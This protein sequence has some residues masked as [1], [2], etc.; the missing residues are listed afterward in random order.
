MTASATV[1]VPEALERE[2]NE[3]HR[4]VRAALMD[5][6][7]AFTASAPL[8]DYVG[9]LRLYLRAAYLLTMWLPE[10]EL[11]RRVAGD[12][13]A[14]IVAMKLFDDLLDG[15]SGFDR[16]EL[17]LCLLLEQR[18][19]SRLA[20]RAPDPQLV[21]DTLE[22]NFVTVGIGQ[23]RTKREPAEDVATWRA[24]AE[25]YGACFLG[26]YGT[27]A[28]LSGGVPEALPAATNFG[29]GFGMIV[30]VADDMRDYERHGE[31]AGNLGHLLLT[32]RAAE[33]EI[34]DLIEQARRLATPPAGLWAAHDVTP[35]VNLYADDV[36]HRVLPA[37]ATL[38]NGIG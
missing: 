32:G 14:H 17:G 12:L 30:T 1:R 5:T 3:G 27:L 20:R 33:E 29:R 11:R 23:L 25:T 24:Y 4:R 22:S 10:V 38:R 35:I 31:R 15:D 26:L 28:A 9:D 7:R 36:L 34:R 19:T 37:M 16:F 13:A 6:M 2:L 21:L 18:A 8:V